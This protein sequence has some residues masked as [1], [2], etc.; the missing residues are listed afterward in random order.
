MVGF[1]TTNPGN[2][3][4]FFPFPFE[5]ALLVFAIVVVGRGGDCLG[6]DEEEVEAIGSEEDEDVEASIDGGGIG[7]DLA[8][9]ALQEVVT[10]DIEFS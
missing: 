6:R 8:V 1:L 2:P 9:T 10:N 5:L 7:T 3:F 4:S